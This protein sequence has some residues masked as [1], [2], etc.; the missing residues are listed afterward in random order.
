[1]FFSNLKLSGAEMVAT[2][3][4]LEKKERKSLSLIIKVEKLIFV[5]R[6]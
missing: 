2:P 5:C 1:M 6:K 3:E 4:L